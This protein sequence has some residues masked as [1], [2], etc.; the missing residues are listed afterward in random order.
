MTD[1]IKTM[2]LKF[3]GKDHKYLTRRKEVMK[4][5]NWEEFILELAIR[6][7]ERRNKR[8]NNPQ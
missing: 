6:D 2:N 4:S 8:K 1:K 3:T 5:S 7:E